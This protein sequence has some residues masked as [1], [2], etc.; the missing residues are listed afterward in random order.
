M[1][2]YEV[3]TDDAGGIAGVG[4]PGEAMHL[5]REL[6]KHEFEEMPRF[7]TVGPVLQC[8]RKEATHGN[9]PRQ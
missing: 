4:D 6:A 9:D 3:E 5:A 7:L 2:S 8:K 1:G